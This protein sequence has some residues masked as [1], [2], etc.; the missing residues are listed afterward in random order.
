MKKIAI[1][2]AVFTISLASCKHA[3]NLE[4]APEVSFKNDIQPIISGNCSQSHCHG[5]TDFRGFLL[6]TYEDVMHEGEITPGDAKN[7]R[8]YQAVTG[9]GER[10]MP[11]SSQPPLT[12]NQ[13]V[14]IYLWIEE[15]AHNN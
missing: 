2:F 9:R 4:N 3:S 8:L 7:S 5:Q 10:Q 14:L 12:D 13:V 15:G 6:A 1:V 11:P